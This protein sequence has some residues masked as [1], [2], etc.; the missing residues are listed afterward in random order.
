[1]NTK[2]GFPTKPD[3]SRFPL[4]IDKS[5]CIDWIP[6]HHPIT[7]WQGSIRQEPHNHMGR[8]MVIS[9]IIPKC[10]VRRSS[11]SYSCLWI[12]FNRMHSIYKFHRILNKKYLKREAEE[13]ISSF[14]SIKLDREPSDIFCCILRSFTAN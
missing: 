9:N 4:F 3:K 5:K 8:L 1:M 14:F 11:L 2:D 7:S 6:I 10:I 12:W 13:I